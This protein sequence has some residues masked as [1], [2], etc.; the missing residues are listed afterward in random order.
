MSFA[1]PGAGGYTDVV[2]LTG[3]WLAVPQQSAMAS[4]A[5]HWLGGVN[6]LVHCTTYHVTRRASEDGQIHAHPRDV[7]R[8][9]EEL[10]PPGREPL[11]GPAAA[12]TAWWQLQA[13][14]AH[15]SGCHSKVLLQLLST[16][17]FLP[18]AKP[19]LLLAG[20]PTTRRQ[21]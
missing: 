20:P 19:L 4:Y 21:Q 17:R 1:L 11:I 12:R 2:L 3:T 6:A 5:G 15:R 18:L 13:R 7:C 16:K 9:I 10:Q 8:G 14:A